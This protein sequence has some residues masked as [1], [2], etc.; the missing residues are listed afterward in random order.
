MLVQIVLE[1]LELAVGDHEGVAHVLR[2][3]IIF[4]PMTDRVDRVADRLVFPIEPLEGVPDCRTIV[5]L[6]CRAG[7]A[8]RIEALDRRE[9]NLF[10]FTEVALMSAAISSKMPAISTTSGWWAP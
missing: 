7:S 9:K 5:G 8:G 3:R 2:Y 1:L 10:L 6:G 4:G